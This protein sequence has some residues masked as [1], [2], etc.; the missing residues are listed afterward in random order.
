MG[1]AAVAAF[2]Q[3]RGPALNPQRAGTAIV[4]I[5]TGSG[6]DRDAYLLTSTGLSPV[7]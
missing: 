2:L 4:D 6:N 1:A 3:G 7:Q 5:V